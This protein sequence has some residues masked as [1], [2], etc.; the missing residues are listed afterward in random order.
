MAY[1]STR[2]GQFHS[3]KCSHTKDGHKDY[4]GVSAQV[5]TVKLQAEHLILY[6]LSQHQ[7]SVQCARCPKHIQTPYELQFSLYTLWRCLADEQCVTQTSV[8]D[9]KR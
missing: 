3:G 2:D 5:V 4:N 8:P 7:S 9:F 1:N 6:A